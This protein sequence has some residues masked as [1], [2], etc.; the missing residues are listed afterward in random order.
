MVYYVREFIPE[1]VGAQE[2]HVKL[3]E[4]LRGFLLDLREKIQDAR[5]SGSARDLTMEEIWKLRAAIFGFESVFIK[6]LG[7]KAIKNYVFS[8]IADILS[9]YLPR[10]MTDS[11]IIDIETKLEYVNHIRSN[12]F[13]KYSRV[14]REGQSFTIAV[15]KCAFAKIHDSRAYRDLHVRFCPWAMIASAI[16]ASHTRRETELDSS[17][18]TTSGSVT[19]ITPT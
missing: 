9:A 11:S 4:E 14:D 18:F 15:N 17:L 19:K 5:E 13:V 3:V 2:D 16:V 8:R 6:I 7:E 10:E 1:M 12:G